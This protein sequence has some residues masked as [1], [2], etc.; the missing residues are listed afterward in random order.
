MKPTLNEV[1]LMLEGTLNPQSPIS[2]AFVKPE[3][4]VA[5]AIE[6]ELLRQLR[7]CDGSSQGYRKATSE[8]VC[9]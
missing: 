9:F 1:T 7:T 6:G 4:S 8:A 2:I 3:N 5:F